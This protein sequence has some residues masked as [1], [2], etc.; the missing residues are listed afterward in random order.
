M[1]SLCDLKRFERITLK[2]DPERA[3]ELRVQHLEI[4]PAYHM[5]KTHWISIDPAGSL[6]DEMLFRLTKDSYNLIVRSLPKKD[7][8]SFFPLD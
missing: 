1:F 4:T 7:Q 6:D 2:S 5:N 8:T 3:V